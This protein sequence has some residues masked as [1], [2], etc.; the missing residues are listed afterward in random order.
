[1]CPVRASHSFTN[2]VQFTQR[3]NTVQFTQSWVGSVSAGVATAVQGASETH[4]RHS[5]GG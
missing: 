3:A 5:L 2:T 1:M 4:I